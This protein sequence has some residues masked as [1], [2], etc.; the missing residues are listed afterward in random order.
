MSTHKESISVVI[1]AYNEEK[2]I[3]ECLQSLK[4]QSY[5]GPIE[6]IVVDNNSS[7]GTARI[8]RE[9]GATVVFEPMP[10]VC[11]ARQAGTL[12]AHGSIV[13]STDADTTFPTNWLERISDTFSTDP[14]IV[15]VGGSFA[16]VDA[17]WWGRIYT[18]IIF[19][20]I[21][22]LIY[23]VS[24]KI[25]CM[26]GSN[27]AFKKSAWDGYDVKLAQGGDEVVLLRQLQKKGKVVMLF[28]NTVLTSARRLE[29]GFWHFL[30]YY[31][32]DYFYC[33][34]TGKS[35]VAPRAIRMQ[36]ESAANP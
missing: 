1:P 16:L 28:D 19:V 22:G 21:I 32:F 8:A 13:V 6:I 14:D 36:K 20:G 3:R 17:P 5:A 29:K 11:A 25:A 24:G 23:E 10:G 33:L 35:M 15:A 31:V 9:E 7:D 2:L 4:K 30:V 26:F 34:I 27:T 18:G 12:A